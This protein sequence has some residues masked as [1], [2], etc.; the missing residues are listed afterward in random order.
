[1]YGRNDLHFFQTL[2]SNKSGVAVNADIQAR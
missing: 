2:P 1:M